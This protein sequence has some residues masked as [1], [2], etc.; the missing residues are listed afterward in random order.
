[1]GNQHLSDEAEKILKRLQAPGQSI[2][3]VIIEHL[4]EKA[5]GKE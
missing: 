2:S 5:E 1:M 4:K 3:G